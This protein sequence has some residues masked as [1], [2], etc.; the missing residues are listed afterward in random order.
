MRRDLRHVLQGAALT[1]LATACT[2]GPVLVSPRL[3]S[4]LAG[5]D[6]ATGPAYVTLLA[7]LGSLV[8]VGASVV[9]GYREQRRHDVHRT[10]RRSAIE[11]GAGGATVVVA[12]A[13]L[14]VGAPALSGDISPLLLVLALL[15]VLVSMPLVVVVATLAGVAL[16]RLPTEWQR[17]DAPFASPLAVPVGAA[18]VAA[19]SVVVESATTLLLSSGVGLP[20]RFSGFGRATMETLSI[21]SS[22]DSLASG[23]LLVGGG[24]LLGI[25]ATR[26][27]DFD[28]SVR[29]FVVLVGVGSLVGTTVGPVLPAVLT[30]STLAGAFGT[31]SKWLVA[32]MASLAS[33]YVETALVVTLAA[34]AGLGIGTFE[35]EGG[36]G[37]PTP[38]TTEPPDGGVAAGDETGT[39]ADERRSDLSPADGTVR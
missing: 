24:V 22:A 31:G 12:A 1:A 36:R 25:Y 10:Y 29:R 3:S 18:V 11:L 19:G 14:A 27:Y 13:T 38:E 4:W 30:D 16:A 21:F 6:P 37:G 33:A 2:L 8:T 15:S 26:R 7:T 32:W 5:S 9:V 39:P 17:S 23:L 20:D 34:V 35:G 28:E